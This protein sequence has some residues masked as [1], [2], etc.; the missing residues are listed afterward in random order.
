MGKLRCP[1]GTMR[2]QVGP[3]PSKWRPSTPDLKNEREEVENP[4]RVEVLSRK[5]GRKGV[6]AQCLFWFFVGKGKRRVEEFI[7][8]TQI[9]GKPVLS[10]AQK[11]TRNNGV[12]R[13]GI[14]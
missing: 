6:F 1:E 2:A 5:R 10:G 13:K 12:L 9:K 14:R 3:R 8:I 11:V 7:K 4:G